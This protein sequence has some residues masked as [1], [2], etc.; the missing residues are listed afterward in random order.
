MAKTSA[1]SRGGVPCCGQNAGTGGVSVGGHS[2]CH[3][4]LLSRLRF[5]LD[6]PAKKGIYFARRRGDAELLIVLNANLKK[7]YLD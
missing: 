4:G 7:L 2:Q 3:G 1:G 5:V 6:I